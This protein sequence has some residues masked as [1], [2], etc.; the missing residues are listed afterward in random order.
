MHFSPRSESKI[1]NTN[2][3]LWYMHGDK[4]T[5]FVICVERVNNRREEKLY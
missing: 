4:I 2:T 3:Y 1:N 5:Q